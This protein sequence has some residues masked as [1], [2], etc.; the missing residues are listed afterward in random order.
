MSNEGNG[1]NARLAPNST[2]SSADGQVD[3]LDTLLVG[4]VVAD[5]LLFV[6]LVISIYT[7]LRNCT[8]R[9]GRVPT[10]TVNINGVGLQT[11]PVVGV[12]E[13]AAVQSPQCRT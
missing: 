12:P 10:A 11:F 13:A 3:L 9:R 4:L 5:G 1:P 2:A 6:I 7:V 8:W